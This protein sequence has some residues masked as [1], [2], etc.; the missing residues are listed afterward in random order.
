M[1]HIGP[2]QADLVISTK[3][4]EAEAVEKAMFECQNEVDKYAN[5]TEIPI[6][7]ANCG[8]VMGSVTAPFTQE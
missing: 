3:R 1:L 8:D 7:L 6:N 4:Q 2:S 5:K